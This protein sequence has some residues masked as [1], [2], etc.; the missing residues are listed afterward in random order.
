VLDIDPATIVAKGRLQP[1][2]MFLVDTERG[3]IRSDA[4]V[5]A[6]LAA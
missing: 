1:G 2:K 6:E 4:E 5:K 3:E